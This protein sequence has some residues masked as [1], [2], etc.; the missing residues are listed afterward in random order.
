MQRLDWII[1]ITVAFVFVMIEK[2]V[3]VK[4][5]S[6]TFWMYTLLSAIV[7]NL[8]KRYILKLPPFDRYD[9]WDRDTWDRDTWN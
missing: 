7:T 6:F 8:I 5:N 1:C 3:G 2:A 9:T 4:F